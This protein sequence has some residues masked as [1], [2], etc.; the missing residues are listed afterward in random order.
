MIHLGTAHELV[1]KF[2]EKLKIDQES[3]EA[4]QNINIPPGDINKTY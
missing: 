4:Q 1:L 3:G 2:I